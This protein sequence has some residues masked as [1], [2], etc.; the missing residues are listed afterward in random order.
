V[1]RVDLEV[2]HGDPKAI[3]NWAILQLQTRLETVVCTSN[4]PSYDEQMGIFFSEYQRWSVGSRKHLYES[5]KT[6]FKDQFGKHMEERREAR[7]DEYVRLLLDWAVRGHQKI[8][9]LIFD[10]TDQFPPEIQDT[11][12][13]LAHSYE[14]AA[15]VFNVVPITDRT[16]WRLSKAGALQSYSARSFY[17][18][19]PDA[20]EIISRR[21]EF[22]KLKVSA[23]PKAAKSYFS[24]RVFQVEV[25]DLAILADAVGKVFVDNDYV[26]GFIGRLGNFD[27]RRM[28]KIAERIFLSPELKIDDIIKS[29]FG[30]D[31]VTAD[32]LRTH[33]ALI[34]GEYDRFTEGENEFISNVFQTN[35]LRPGPP[36]LGYYLLWLLRQ[37]LNNT[38]IDD[39]NVEHRHWLASDLC[40]LFEGCG[41]AEDL[42]MR[43]LDRLYERRLIEALDPTSKYVSIFDRVA[44]KESGLAHLELMLN[45]E[46]Y[47]E[48]MA[49]IT[50]VN[51]L[52]A[53]DEIKKNLHAGQFTSLREVFLRYVLKIDNGRLGIPSNALYSQIHSAR[54]QIEGLM[55]TGRRSKSQL[56][57]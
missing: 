7:P 35:A 1:A 16:V 51:E 46:V 21:V 42:V 48:Q 6:E 45:S 27:I 55:A 24:K 53:R 56:G 17:L 20:K 41:V 33:R 37:K 22:L 39:D 34:K 43:S 23:E 38:R 57:S 2:Y 5:N 44:I 29:K 14:S 9:C 8:P 31:N 54:T 10:N 3:V 32:R 11:I 28:L 12:Y 25:N 13:Q 47:I 50:G 15:P 36:L 18:P 4:P 30:G 40:Q 26:S 49:L 19:V 52:F